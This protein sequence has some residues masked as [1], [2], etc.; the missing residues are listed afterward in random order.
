MSLRHLASVSL[1]LA[2]AVVA[3]EGQIQLREGPGKELVV[4][5]CAMCH[6][7][8][9]IPMN[10]PILDRKGWEGSVN[11]M[12]KVMGAP[13]AAEDAARIMEYLATYYGTAAPPAATAVAVAAAPASASAP[14]PRTP[15]LLARGK[16]SYGTYCAA[17]H[18]PAGAG[19][20]PAARALR[21]APKDLTT[22]SGGAPGVYA[23]LDTGVKGTAMVA[24]RHLSEPDRWAIAHFVESLKET[25]R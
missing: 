13:I 3:D 2:R 1:L 17:C 12:I 18:G 5:H 16:A 7:L 22:V 24:F 4:A 8:D 23:V 14:P 6:S 11:K 19:D 25:R 9:Y 10:S 15:E 21:P 20:G